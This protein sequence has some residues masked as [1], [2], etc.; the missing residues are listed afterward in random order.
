M[1]KKQRV[2]V[3]D[4]LD[5]YNTRKTRRGHSPSFSYIY[6]LIRNNIK[7]IGATELWFEYELDPEHKDRIWILI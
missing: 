6:R 4:W 1:K 3:Q 7:G 5:N 2:S